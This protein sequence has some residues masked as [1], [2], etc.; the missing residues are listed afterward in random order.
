MS[1][2]HYTDTL[3][4]V[5]RMV[6]ALQAA[7]EMIALDRQALADAHTWPDGL[8]EYGE[9]G[10]ADYTAVMGQIDAALTLVTGSPAPLCELVRWRLATDAER[11][12]A[13]MTVL[14]CLEST[15]AGR[16][17]E[18]GWWNGEEWCLCE[19]GGPAVQ[20]DVLA[21]AVAEGPGRAARAAWT[22][23]CRP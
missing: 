6:E 7:R 13:E 10:V 17:V 2:A 18:C 12:D 14:L 19:S 8:D 16:S 3:A 1:A 20:A 9:A 15:E 23:R 11:P 21:W 5:R 4:Q 22:N